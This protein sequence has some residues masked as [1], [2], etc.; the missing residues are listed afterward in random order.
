[1]LQGTASLEFWQTYTYQEIQPF[2]IELNNE[3]RVR[4]EAAEADAAV[5]EPEE[6]VD[7]ELKSIEEEL[8]AATGEV[9]TGT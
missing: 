7:S 1:L 3:V 4:I 8:A 2:L 6:S 5:A 9:S